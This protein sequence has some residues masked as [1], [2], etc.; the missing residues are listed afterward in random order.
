MRVECI[1]CGEVELWWVF[2]LVS[3]GIGSRGK[4]DLPVGDEQIVRSSGRLPP[5]WGEWMRPADA[6]WW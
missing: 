3:V 5:R 6:D 2:L 4:G 1:A